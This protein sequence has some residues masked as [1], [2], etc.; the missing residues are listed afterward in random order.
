MVGQLVDGLAAYLVGWTV[1]TKVVQMAGLWAAYLA[2]LKAVHWVDSRA[3]SMAGV[4][5]DLKADPRVAYLAD[6]LDYP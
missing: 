1:A 2:D 4:M 5:A 3:E 6:P